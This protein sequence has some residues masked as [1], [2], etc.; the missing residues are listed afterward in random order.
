MPF[1]REPIFHDRQ[2]ITLAGPITTTSATFVDIPGATI[3]TKDLS[4][5][6]FY[7]A[8]ISLE[9]ENTNNNTTMNFRAITAGVPGSARAVNIGPG[10]G[11]DP[12]SVTII[13]DKSGIVASSIIKLQWNTTGGTAQINSLRFLIDGIPDSR[14][15]T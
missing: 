8:W 3:T 5:T 10:G 12:K 7:Q 2:G 9:V 15:V 11:G 14:V 4:Q 6:G 1:I 13:G